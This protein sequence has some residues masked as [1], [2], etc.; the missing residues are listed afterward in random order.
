M[1]VNQ[2]PIQLSSGGGADG[3]LYLHEAQ[4]DDGS[5]LIRR[6]ARRLDRLARSADKAGDLTTLALDVAMEI[7]G[8]GGLSVGD[9]RERL[10]APKQSLARA[11]NELEREG[12]TR[13]SPSQRDGRRRLVELTESGKN[14]ASAAADR[15]REALR[16]ALL[17]AGPSAA[18]GAWDV[19]ALLADARTDG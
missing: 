8:H 3:R 14:L 18:A 9:L 5:A 17:I 13:R 10:E 19:L 12:L 2:A 4:L 16:A 7:H 6:A 11:L 1:R 15:R